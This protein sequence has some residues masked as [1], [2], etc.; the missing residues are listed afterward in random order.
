MA[1]A[2]FDLWITFGGANLK[3]LSQFPKYSCIRESIL[4]AGTG[5]PVLLGKNSTVKPSV[6][7]SLCAVYSEVLWPSKPAPPNKTKMSLTCANQPCRIE[8]RALITKELFLPSFLPPLLISFQKPFH[9]FH[10]KSFSYL[11]DG[12]PSLSFTLALTS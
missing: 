11:R 8:W 6:S 10:I 5:T 9:L 7:H 3:K 2:S 4:G 1:N 12:P